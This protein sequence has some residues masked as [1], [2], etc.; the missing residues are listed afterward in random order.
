MH[1]TSKCQP[2]RKARSDFD[3]Y[4]HGSGI[5]IGSGPDPLKVEQGTVRAWDHAD[6]DAQL[7][8]GVADGQ[9][10]F[11]YSSHCL[12][13]M[14]DVPETL[15]NWSRILKPAGVLYF[16]VP[17]YLLYE[18]L[19]WPSRFNRDHKHSFS[20]VITRQHVQRPNHWHI[21][22]DIQPLL[23]ELGLEIVRIT[24]EDNGFN[25]N[26]GLFDQTVQDTLAQ[27][28]FVARKK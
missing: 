5:D 20:F 18:K 6:G 15:R 27:L 19:T 11:V 3:R 4:L 23:T 21:N 25:Y 12:E 28:C 13:H 22:E 26:A 7:M 9:F 1:E 10:D 17:D 2:M 8:P 16:V 24:I 14:R